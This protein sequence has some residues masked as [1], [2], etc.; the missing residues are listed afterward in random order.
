LLKG[1]QP[2]VK[3]CGKRKAYKVFALIDYCSRHLFGE[4]QTERFTSGT[5]AAF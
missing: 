1:E 2:I 4:G 3:T 5:Y